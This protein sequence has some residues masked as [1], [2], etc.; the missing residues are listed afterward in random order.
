MSTPNDVPK[1]TSNPRQFGPRDWPT[2]ASVETLEDEYSH[3]TP[4]QPGRVLSTTDPIRRLATLG[5]GLGPLLAIVG[6]ILRAAYGRGGGPLGIGTT[7]GIGAL[8]TGLLLFSAVLFIA[9]LITLLVKMP[10]KRPDAFD[11]PDDG[12]VV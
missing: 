2:N 11:T 10:A 7:S 5:A 1:R 3:F 6:L 9:S 12:A 8:I 4:P